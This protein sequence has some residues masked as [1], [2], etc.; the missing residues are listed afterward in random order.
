LQQEPLG[1]CSSPG[2]GSLEEAM[3]GLALFSQERLH[4]VQIWGNEVFE[5]SSIV[6]LVLEIAGLIEK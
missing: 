1:V 6:S 5:D 4:N 2:Q 3:L